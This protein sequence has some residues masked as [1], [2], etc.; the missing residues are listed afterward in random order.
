MSLPFRLLRSRALR[1]LVDQHSCIHLGLFLQPVS[2]SRLSQYSAHHRPDRLEHI[3]VSS[4]GDQVPRW[5]RWPQLSQSLREP[6][7]DLGALWSAEGRAGTDGGDGR[8]FDE[9][10]AIGTRRGLR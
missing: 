3:D 1:D 2:R 7:G 8:S 5:Q 6:L 10:H 9:D 4:E